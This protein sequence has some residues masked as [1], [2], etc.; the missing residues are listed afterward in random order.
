MSQNDAEAR[1]EMRNKEAQYHIEHKYA[2]NGFARA[3]AELGLKIAN[4]MDKAGSSVENERHIFTSQMIG[5]A[6]RGA[7]YGA[8]AAFVAVACF[9]P[10]IA[11]ILPIY[12]ACMLASA[13]SYAVIDSTVELNRHKTHP[14]RKLSD[15]VAELSGAVP[16]KI[17][18]VE[19]DKSFVQDPDRKQYL[20]QA[21]A[22]LKDRGIEVN[23]KRKNGSPDFTSRLK[24]EQKLS[25]ASSHSR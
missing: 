4:L 10:P 18:T 1:I 11:A 6:I 21:E 25:V 13:A 24:K 19:F 2:D 14:E 20:E 9:A 22:L 15:Q 23:D 16:D 17:K 12:A 7:V 3:K 8:V 5:G